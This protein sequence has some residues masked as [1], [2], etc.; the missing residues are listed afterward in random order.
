VSAPNVQSILINPKQLDL[1]VQLAQI[2]PITPP[3]LQALIL[4][5]HPVFQ[6][7]LKFALLVL[8]TQLQVC[9]GLMSLLVQLEQAL[10]L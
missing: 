6:L 4:H 3:Y 1:V 2:A 5:R 7:I 10:Q 9:L 8:L